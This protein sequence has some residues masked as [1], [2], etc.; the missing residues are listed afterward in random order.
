MSLPKAKKEFGQ[1]FLKDAKVIETIT[2]D[3]ADEADVIIEV[4]PGPAIL[5]KFLVQKDKPFYV[6]EK[7][8]SFEQYLCPILNSE[9]I[10]FQDALDFDWNQ[11]I[12][13]HKLKDKNI[14]LVSNLPYNVGTVLFTQFLKIQQIKYMTLMF[15]KEVGDKTYK[16]PHRPQMNGLYFLS[17]NY[18]DSKLL[19]KVAPGAF[20][21]PPKVDSV[22]VSYSR[23]EKPDVPIEKF[24]SLNT[25]T[26][27]LFNM[28]RK[29]VAKVLKTFAGHHD[30]ENI[31]KNS[32][33]EKSRRAETLSYQE[34]LELYQ[35][36]NDE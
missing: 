31:L 3:W 5:T 32:H 25:F 34:V 7:D 35:N 14:W 13:K 4:G 22:V 1:H 18:F 12:K 11:F 21:P 23:K 15:Q 8:H 9:N 6:I 36:L 33:I 10:F 20:N 29:Q 16:H 26:R 24:K 28:K 30:I 19:L 2:S 17:Q 27:N